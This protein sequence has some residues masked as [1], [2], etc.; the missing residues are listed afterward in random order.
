MTHV[1]TRIPDPQET[2]GSAHGPERSLRTWRSGE[3]TVMNLTRADGARFLRADSPAL[4]WGTAAAVVAIVG[5]AFVLSFQALVE[6]AQ[7]AGVSPA[8]ALAFP[9][10]VDG[11][12]LTGTFGSV[13]LEPRSRAMR[14]YGF[15]VLGV[16][17][18][19][20]VWANGMHA[21]SEL[22]ALGPVERWVIG[23]AAPVAVLLGT[24]LLVTMLRPADRGPTDAQRVEELEA[25][26]ARAAAEERRVAVEARRADQADRRAGAASAPRRPATARPTTGSR[27]HAASAARKLFEANGEWPARAVLVAEGFSETTAKRGISDAK[28]AA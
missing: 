9:I 2:I 5:A 19:V 22:D 13:I 23:A 10:A 14:A 3:M 1:Q 20:S 24:H 7:A 12:V 18:A 17:A 26:A 28:A 27:A 15:A 4:L 8:V 21:A 25:Q 6:V 16:G 11:L